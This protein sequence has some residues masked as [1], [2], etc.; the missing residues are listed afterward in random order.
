MPQ[1]ITWVILA[2]VIIFALVALVIIAQ[3]FNLWFQAFLSGASV[4]FI[5]L[6]GMKFRKVDPRII[7]LNRIQAV[8]AGLNV[9]TKELE[10]HLLAGGRV[11]LVIRALIAADRAKIELGFNTACAIG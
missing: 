7:V 8:K 3:F 2:V 5:D 11:P 4:S 10:T 9:T 6:I 1:P